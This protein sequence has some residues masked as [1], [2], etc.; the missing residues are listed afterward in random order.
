MS[1]TSGDISTG[2]VFV[3]PQDSS[4]S[5]GAADQTDAAEFH[6]IAIRI[7]GVPGQ[8]YTFTMD[9]GGVHEL[10]HWWAED[11]SGAVL[12]SS[13]GAPNS[14]NGWLYG[15]NNA[16]T[17]GPNPINA[18][19]TS[20]ISYTIP[21]TNTDGIVILRVL[22]LDPQASH[23][24][25]EFIGAPECHAP[26]LD[27]A[28]SAS[29]GAQNADGTFDVTY[30]VTVENTGNVAI[31]DLTLVDDLT[32]ANQLGSAYS[33]VVTA[34]VV[35][36]GST[37]TAAST[38]PTTNGAAYNGTNDLLIGTDGT[39]APGD[40]Y[41]VT[42]TVTVD[43]NAAGAPATL[44]NTAVAGGEDP[45]NN[46]VSDDSDTDTAP[47]GSADTTANVPGGA[48]D[49]TVIQAPAAGVSSIG[50]TKEITGV[51]N[52]ASGTVGNFDVTYAFVIEN[53]GALTLDNL[54]LT[55]DFANQ[56]GGAFEGIVGTPTIVA[57]TGA[58]APLADA[59]YD[60]GTMNANVLDAVSGEIE[61]GETIT[62][63]IVVEIDPD[64]PTGM[65]NA[66][67]E[68][69]NQAIA[70]GDDPNGG[71]PDDTS[72]DPTVSTDA[73]SNGD[74]EPDDPTALVIPS[75]NTEK[76]I[77][78]FAAAA[79][80]TLGN[81][82]VAYEITLENTGNVIVDNLTLLE[83]FDTQFGNAF[84]GIVGTPT[85][86]AGTGA[87]A[88]TLSGTY[89]GGINDAELFNTTSGELD[90]GETIT[91]TIVAEVDPNAACLLYTSPSPRDATLSRMPSSA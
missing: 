33:G 65:F 89:D 79:S 66:N 24:N 38:L 4:V 2:G 27:A 78:A 43:P 57:G 16:S 10:L 49:P 69:E 36:A 70:G 50:L 44:Q 48:G 64:S 51:T 32:A 85:V 91:I 30:T 37:F 28:K 56:F 63:T 77:S 1:V 74:G 19:Q 35:S 86:V 6:R 20:T 40:I 8:S 39:L 62:V 90:P 17:S 12:N 81:Y 13:L 26:E 54:R 21:P 18:D 71:T 60:G 45:L 11:S 34:P 84:V 5:G 15:T 7:D 82:D 76:S 87:V 25:L 61:P 80:G 83:D 31:D 67:G 52:A 3:V 9:N 75:V 29:V 22:M 68:L 23:G 53:T 73:D 42:F 58:V 14:A 41:E 46:P 55:E 47:D 59:T 88:P 72:D